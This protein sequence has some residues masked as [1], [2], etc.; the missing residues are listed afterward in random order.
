MRVG[1]CLANHSR[2][3]GSA[4]IH[5]MCLLP[6]DVGKDTEHSAGASAA[7]V[8]HK[9]MPAEGMGT[10]QDHLHRQAG[11]SSTGSSCVGSARA[12]CPELETAVVH[13]TATA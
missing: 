1:A 8:L 7:Q 3:T 11:S 13:A 2:I 10:S 6:S 12:G 4:W 5:T 9:G